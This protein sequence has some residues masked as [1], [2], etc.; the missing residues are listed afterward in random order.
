MFPSS[1]G[2]PIQKP[3]SSGSNPSCSFYM[4]SY[5]SLIDMEEEEDDRDQGD[6]ETLEEEEEGFIPESLVDGVVS[7]NIKRHLKP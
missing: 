4:D 3:F 5:Q 1:R 7:G 6:L 2:R